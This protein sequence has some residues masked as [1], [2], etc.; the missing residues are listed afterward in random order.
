MVILDKIQITVEV[1]AERR[2]E[3]ICDAEK[4]FTLG[5]TYV[6]LQQAVHLKF[7]YMLPISY[8]TIFKLTL[9]NERLPW[10]NLD[11]FNSI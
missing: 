2:L 4:L 10:I 7:G 1:T 3:K 5:Y 6:K 8:N 11:I 9:K